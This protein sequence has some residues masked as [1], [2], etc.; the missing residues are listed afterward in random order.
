MAEQPLGSISEYF[1][2]LADPRI[3]RNKL[4][5]LLNIIVIAICAVICGA[6]NWVDVELYGNLKKEWLGKYLDLTNGIPSHDTF[7]RVFRRLKAEAFQACF[8]A[9]VKAVNTLTGG[10]VIAI[11]GKE[12]R[13]SLDETLGKRAIRMVS[14]WASENRLVLAQQKVDEKSNEIT[15]IPALLELLEIAGCI[16]TIDAMGCQ[17]EIAQQITDQQGDYVLAVKENQGHL[18]EDIEH[19]CQLYL[20]HEQPM[21][22][23]NDY[24]KTVDK[25]HDRIEI[26]ECWTLDASFYGPSIRNIGEWAKIKTLI[27]IRRERRLPDKTEVHT[28]Y[29]ISSLKG[30]AERL[31]QVIREHWGIE[32]SVHWVLD[33][34]FN[35]DQSRLH[36]DNGAENLAVIRHIA[37]NLLR[38]EQTAKVGIK[39]KR[40]KAGWDDAYLFKVLS[41]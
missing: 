2:Q 10:Q 37:L 3:E 36:K 40:L 29:Y 39:A 26:R 33:M 21:F 13:R 41:S 34:A 32:N 4:H 7:G 38:N 24:A 22:Y 27:M 31:L 5:P 35:E 15:A 30:T 28:R 16:I 9:W 18:F 19:L 20:Q 25:D 12:L 14:A 1:G 17:T 11:D 8:L 23:F 6:E